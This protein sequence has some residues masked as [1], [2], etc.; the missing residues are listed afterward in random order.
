MRLPVTRRSLVVLLLAALC[1]CSNDHR[2]FAPFI[3][4]V[5]EEVW[6]WRSGAL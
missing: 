5:T 2:L 6:S 1:G 3:P 4:F